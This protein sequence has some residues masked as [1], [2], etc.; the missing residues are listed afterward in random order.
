MTFTEI[1]LGVV[2]VLAMIQGALIHDWAQDK[3]ELRA[4]GALEREKV[5]SYVGKPKSGLKGSK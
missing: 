2:I 5:E 1:Q 4:L 3:A